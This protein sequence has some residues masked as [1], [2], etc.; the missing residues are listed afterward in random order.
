MSSLNRPP[1]SITTWTIPGRNNQTADFK[2]APWLAEA[3]EITKDKVRIDQSEANL[4]EIT[5]PRPGPAAGR[6]NA[7]TTPQV[8]PSV[9]SVEVKW[10]PYSTFLCHVCVKTGYLFSTKVRD[11]RRYLSPEYYRVKFSIFLEI[12]SRDLIIINTC[13]VISRHV[14]QSCTSP[15]SLTPLECRPR[16]LLY[17]NNSGSATQSW[18]T[19]IVDSSLF[20]RLFTAFS[21]YSG[22]AT[23]I[24]QLRGRKHTN[25][26]PRGRRIF[27]FHGRSYARKKRRRSG[28]RG[29]RPTFR[30]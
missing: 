16:A 27:Y 29:T 7:L 19:G 21:L 1:F 20:A 28:W 15:G 25:R 11:E 14:D 10:H 2:S 8:A 26:N 30:R 13:T 24:Q 23:K 17:L 9:F 3:G 18:I 12:I 4:S 6:Q 5:T 22:A